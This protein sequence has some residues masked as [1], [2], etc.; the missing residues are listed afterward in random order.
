MHL[1]QYGV[2]LAA[3]LTLTTA[4]GVRAAS[5]LARCGPSTGQSY[6]FETGIVGP[7][8]GG[9]KKDGFDNGRIT[10]YINDEN[11]IDII[12]RD[13]NGVRSYLRE[14]Y[15]ASLNN[16]SKQDMA[17]LISARGSNFS[18][19]Y[20]FKINDLGVGTLSWTASKVTPLVIRTTVMTAEWGPNFAIEP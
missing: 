2:L 11:K 12:M 9:W 13:G 5:I 15:N 4:G 19:T 10:A 16:F 6:Y 3:A 14:G 20:L 1:D 18:E 7:G 17:F 8:Q